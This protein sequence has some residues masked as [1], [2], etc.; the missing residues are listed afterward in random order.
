MKRLTYLLLI[1]TVFSF[2]SSTEAF[3]QRKA[4]RARERM[5]MVKKMKLLETLN[6]NEEESEKFL[7]KYSFYENKISD[8]INQIRSETA[9]LEEMI[10]SEKKVADLKSK[11]DIIAKLRLENNNLLAERYA[12]ISKILSEE[13]YA[14]FVLFEETFFHRLNSAIGEERRKRNKK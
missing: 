7:V 8:N 11:A 14:K 2:L 9:K 5:Q 13:N 4:H 12:E 3:S 1:L 10:N 6:L